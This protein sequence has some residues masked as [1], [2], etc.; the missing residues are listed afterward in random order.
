VLNLYFNGSRDDIGAAVQAARKAE[1]HRPLGVGAHGRRRR[2]DLE[3]AQHWR[4]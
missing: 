2:G 1:A 4:N 3:S